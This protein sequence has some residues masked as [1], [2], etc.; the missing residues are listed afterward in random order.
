MVKQRNANRK[1]TYNTF[2]LF[3]NGNSYLES[4]ESYFPQL[5]NTHDVTTIRKTLAEIDA[6][7]ELLPDGTLT[8]YVALWHGILFFYSIFWEL[9]CDNYIF[10]NLKSLYLQRWPTSFRCLFPSWVCTNRLSFRISK[11]HLFIFLLFKR[12]SIGANE[13][14]L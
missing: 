3:L 5:Y 2:S 12:F 13:A 14:G 4:I 1:E 7:G 11:E 10:M 6:E 9:L 8:V